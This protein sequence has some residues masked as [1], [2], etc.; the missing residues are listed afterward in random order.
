MAFEVPPPSWEPPASG[1][2]GD[3]PS[4]AASGAAGRNGGSCAWSGIV[5]GPHP[6]QLARLTEYADGREAVPIDME[7]VERIDFVAAGACYNAVRS[8]EERGKSVQ[9]VGATPVIRAM[10]QLIGI[11]AGH[12]HP[13]LS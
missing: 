5:A 11:P 12:F 6:E 13:Q 9:I 8:L 3:Q 1:E 7:R 4:A 10:L 2:A